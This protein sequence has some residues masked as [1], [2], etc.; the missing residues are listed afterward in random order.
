MIEIINPFSGAKFNYTGKNCTAN[1]DY[2]VKDGVLFHVGVNGSY[3]KGGETIRFTADRDENGNVN[4]NG[5]QGQFLKDVAA[6]VTDIM[7][8]VEAQATPAQPASEE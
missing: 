4:I 8:E 5:V 6:E 3:T 2:D 7:A 1:G